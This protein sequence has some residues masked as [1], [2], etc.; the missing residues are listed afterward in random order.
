MLT[1]S[2]SE[3][4][5]GGVDWRRGGACGVSGRTARVTVLGGGVFRVGG[6]EHVL[7]LLLHLHVYV[8]MGRTRAP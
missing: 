5:A 6:S 7:W 3:V 8:E 1:F 4:N 2:D